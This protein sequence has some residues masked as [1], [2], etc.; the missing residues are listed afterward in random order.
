MTRPRLWL[1]L[2][3]WLAYLALTLAA[4]EGCGPTARDHVIAVGNAVAAGSD[5][6]GAVM[7]ERYCADQMRAIGREGAYEGGRCRASGEPRE[8][9]EAELAELARVRE[10]WRPVLRAHEAVARSHNA[11]TA[12]LAA[13]DAIDRDAL[14]VALAH[15]IDAYEELTRAAGALGINLPRLSGGAQ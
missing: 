3:G 1:Q 4:V 2:A 13:A 11:L 15:V 10:A 9:T 14:L 6:A 7:L 8:A 12:S 5:A